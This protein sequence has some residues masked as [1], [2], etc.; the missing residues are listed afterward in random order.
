M[1]ITFKE[2]TFGRLFAK[3]NIGQREGYN[4]KNRKNQGQNVSIP[5]I[6]EI[7]EFILLNRYDIYTKIIPAAISKVKTT[8]LYAEPIPGNI[9]LA[10]AN[11]NQNTE[12]L[13]AKSA[14]TESSTGLNL[15]INSIY[16]I[17]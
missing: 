4:K 2:L 12:K 3:G 5:K 11:P 6:S 7:H 17:L 13:M 1:I 10:I 9:G 14:T 8:D 16:H 15:P